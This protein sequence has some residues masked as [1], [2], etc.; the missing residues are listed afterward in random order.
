M[1]M[2]QEDIEEFLREQAVKHRDE[3]TNKVNKGDPEITQEY[4]SRLT[5]YLEKRTTDILSDNRSACRH[6]AS[7]LLT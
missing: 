3:L 4:M 6:Y 1:P 7:D 5:T 2:N